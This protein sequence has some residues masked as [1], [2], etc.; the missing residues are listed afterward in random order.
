MREIVFDIDKI[1]SRAI[2]Q[3]GYVTTSQAAEEGVSKQS[4]AML[5]KRDRLERVA[6]GLYR[7]PQVAPTSFDRFMLALLWAGCPEVTLS[8][9]TAFDAYEVCDVLPVAIHIT[10]GS[11]RSCSMAWI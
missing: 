10:V 2:D 6:H 1:R 5:V 8:H 4:L 7:V 11:K 3:Y 9:E